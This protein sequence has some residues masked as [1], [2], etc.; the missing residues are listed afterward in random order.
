MIKDGFKLEH[1]LL[2]IFFFFL[3]LVTDLFFIMTNLLANHFEPQL[4]D[5]KETKKKMQLQISQRITFFCLLLNE[6]KGIHL[7]A[8][9]LKVS[10]LI[11]ICKAKCI[12]MKLDLFPL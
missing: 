7:T 10:V 3:R 12:F 8:V 2:R 1:G 9:G 4:E 6:N 11:I 5:H